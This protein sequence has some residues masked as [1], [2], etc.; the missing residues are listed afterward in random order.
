M[1]YTI[2]NTPLITPLLRAVSCIIL[3]VA[4]W[5]FADPAPRHAKYVAVFAPHTSNWDLPIALFYALALRVNVVWLGKDSLFRFPFYSFF[6]WFGGMPVDRGRSQNVVA[7]V[8]ATYNSREQFVAG[9]APEGTR[10]KVGTWKTGFY[11][12]ACGAGVP[13]ALAFIDYKKKIAG[14]GPVLEPSGNL[15]TDMQT[16]RAFYSGVTGKN[17][18]QQAIPDIAP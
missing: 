12:I 17:P 2:F 8:V 15:E 14:F 4:R 10:K 6:S 11:H 18:D 9:I 3:R 13:I 5:G 7:Q 16:I 1:R